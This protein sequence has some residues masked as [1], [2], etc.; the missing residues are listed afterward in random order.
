MRQNRLRE[1]GRGRGRNSSTFLIQWQWGR[2]VLHSL[3]GAGGEVSTFDWRKPL[4]LFPSVKY[5]CPHFSALIPVRH[6][7]RFLLFKSS[8][9]LETILFS[10]RW[11][12][13]PSRA[14]TCQIGRA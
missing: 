12:G 14:P 13:W 8:Y 7:L 9:R 6:S 5:F 1:R 2:P 4:P 11:N 10:P 3:G